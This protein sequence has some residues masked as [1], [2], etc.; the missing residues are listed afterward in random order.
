[1]ISG[2]A[3]GS[4]LNTVK[5][6]GDDCAGQGS[7]RQDVRLSSC[8]TRALLPRISYP[9]HL[10]LNFAISNGLGPLLLSH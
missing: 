8:K 2:V 6:L 10:G 4:K 1:M 5:V 3:N 7:P 9:R